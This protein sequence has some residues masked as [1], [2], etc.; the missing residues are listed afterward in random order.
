MYGPLTTESSRARLEHTVASFDRLPDSGLVNVRVVSAVL[1][2]STSSVWR[3]VKEG[4]IARPIK[5][6]GSARWRV[7]DVRFAM[8]GGARHVA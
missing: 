4:R 3:D 7:R 2:R 1:G 8:T 6:G 5:I